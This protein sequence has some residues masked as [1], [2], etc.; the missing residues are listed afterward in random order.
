MEPDGTGVFRDIIERFNNLC[1]LLIRKC[2]GQTRD[3]DRMQARQ[4]AAMRFKLHG[5]RISSEVADVG[6]IDHLH[7]PVAAQKTR[8]RQAAPK[9]GQANVGAGHVPLVRCFDNLH[10][11]DT[12]DALSVHVDQLL[13]E[14]ILR[15][16]NFA[17]A[18]HKWAQIQYVGIQT[19]TV[20]AEIRDAPAR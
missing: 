6:P 15:Q 12:H 9:P 2:F 19:H 10:V 4:L 1:A 3:F 5:R 14:H 20:L 16:Q 18:P 11:V 13:V 17:V 8:R 7:G